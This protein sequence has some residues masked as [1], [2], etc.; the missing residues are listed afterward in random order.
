MLDVQKIWKFDNES[1]TVV[2]VST[3]ENEAM[4]VDIETGQYASSIESL[5][6]LTDVAGKEVLALNLDGCTVCIRTKGLISKLEEQVA[7]RKKE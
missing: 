1:E 5:M 7:L 4:R 6:I 3:R 2:E